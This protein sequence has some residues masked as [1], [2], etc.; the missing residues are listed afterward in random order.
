MANRFLE[1]QNQGYYHAAG[2]EGVNNNE[3]IIAT[4]R[5]HSCTLPKTG[6]YHQTQADTKKKNGLV[7]C[8]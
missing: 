1:N 7:F 4:S 3:N 8:R 6:V 5:H 2:A